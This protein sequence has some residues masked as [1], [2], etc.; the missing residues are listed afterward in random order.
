MSF[1]FLINNFFTI[2]TLIK[3]IVI[4]FKDLKGLVFKY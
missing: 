1:S 2:T 4:Y 3:D